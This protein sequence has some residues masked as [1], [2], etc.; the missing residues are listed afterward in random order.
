MNMNL[1]QIAMIQKLKGGM[2]RFRIN[3]PKFPL[4]LNAV[5]Q[6]ALIEG[7]VVE[8]NVTTPEGRN[9]CSNLRLKQEDLE[10]IE[11][12]KALRQS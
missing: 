11:S 7:T 10:F 5:S 9:Y 12:L 2:D 8:I 4:F 6:D 3:H 1:N